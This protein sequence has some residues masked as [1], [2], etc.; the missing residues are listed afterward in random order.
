M[1]GITLV[2]TLCCARAQTDSPFSGDD[3]TAMEELIEQAPPIPAASV[4]HMG[5]FWSAQHA[6]DTRFPW[7]PLP[8]NILG[9]D[10]WSLG[11]GGYLLNDTNLD[12]DALAAAMAT[13]QAAAAPTPMFRMS[14][15]ASSL[16]SAYAY[17]NPVYLTNLVVTN[18]G[19]GDMT[20]SFNIAGGTNF[21]PYDIL[22]TT[23]LLDHVGL[24]NWL[25]IGYTAH[26]YGFSNQ[27]APQS[28]YILAKPQKTMTVA[29]GDDFFGEIDEP[30]GITNAVMVV[31]NFA[32]SMALLNDGTITGWGGNWAPTNLTGV[33]MLAC[34]DYFNVALFTNGTVNAW[35]TGGGQTTTNELNVPANLTNATVI[36]AQG[37]VALALRGNGTVVAWGNSTYGQTNVPA[38]LSNVTAIA[39]GYKHCLAVS[40]G[41]V[42]AWGNNSYGQ[43]SIPAGLSNVW[44]VAASWDHSVALKKDGTVACWGDKNQGLG[45][46]NVPAGLSNVVAIAAG[47]SYYDGT[48]YTLVL[49]SDGSLVS[50]GTS[51]ALNPV[52]GLT[53]VI[54]IGSGGEQALAIRTG[55]PTP[56][57]T[58]EPTDQY[59]VPGGE[60]DFTAM[61][62]GLYGVTYQWQ[63]NG[64]NITGATNATLALTNVQA[65]QEM[66]YYV[67]ITDIGGMGSIVSSNANFYLLTPP[68]VD[69]VAPATNTAVLYNSTENL[70]VTASGPGDSGDF[71]LSYQWEFNGVDISGA[72]SSNYTF[73]AEASGIYTVTISNDIGGLSVSWQ[74]TV[75]NEGGI[76]PWGSNPNGELNSPLLVTN[77]ISLAAGKAQGIAALDS[78]SVTNWGSY[79][80]GTN[81]VSVTAPPLLTNTMAVAAGSRHDLALKTDGTITAWGLN[82]FGQTNVPAGATNTIA[83][84]AGGQQS[85]ALLQNGT[86]VQWG[87]T[88][89]AV[90]AGLAGVTAIA[91]GTNFCLALLSNATVVAWGADNYGQTNVPAGLTNVVAIAAGGAHALALEQNGTVVTWGAWTNV[92]AGLTNAMKIAAGDNQS[93]AI[94]NDG[95]MTAWGDNSYGQTNI[96]GGLTGIKLIAGG[97]DFSLAAA[98][99]PTV[100]YPVNV[101]NDLLLIYNTNSVNSSTVV[102]YYL[103]HRPMV[104]G[105]NV[106]GIGCTNVETFLLA[107]YTNVFAAQVQAWLASNPTKRPQYVVLFP[108]IPSRVNTNDTP[109]WYPWQYFPDSVLLAHQWPSVQYQLATGCATGWNPFVTSINMNGYGGTNDCIGYI[110]KIAAIGTNVFAGSPIVSASANGYGNTN[111]YCDDSQGIYPI[112]PFGLWA[113]QG[114]TSN[115]VPLS[116]VDYQPFTSTNRITLGTNMAGFCSW[117]VY[118]GGGGNYYLTMQ[119]KGNSGWYLIETIESFNGEYYTTGQGSYIKWYSTNAF[120]GT[121]YSS[122]PIGAVT[123]VD[124]PGAVD[125]ENSQIYFGLWAAGKNFAICAWN[126]RQTPFFQAVGDPFVRR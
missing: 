113:L 50:W 22:T 115:G 103:A 21:V 121:N 119:F 49:K 19:A 105:A 99:S 122:T 79:W 84:A 3:I 8:G 86:V 93:L 55:P 28:F 25:G 63:T 118:N 13:A 12:Y 56:V 74:V 124:E 37:S 70:T 85:L 57:L 32:E 67:V 92:P 29:W 110:N 7:P 83:I 38:A 65:A 16:A 94:L 27:P 35:A 97:G 42:V 77:V 6:P 106:L 88:N 98:F 51:D 31:G 100:M 9:L 14:M 91:A 23:N 20:A 120:G 107:E 80:T 89:A 48:A 34:G 15:M 87:Q 39:V 71:P 46:T 62:V 117:G 126:A 26:G 47:G 30:V 73:D 125:C 52:V 24:W 75:F 61:G 76:I 60:A 41:F 72:T 54:A 1:C 109:G 78:G 116:D 17:G 82:D 53:N 104:S 81:Y 90:P 69:A 44:D 36:S 58:L 108:D 4:P 95:T 64:V 10:A 40:N 11:D 43:T 68:V 59:Q 5:T 114:V 112:Y 111:Y 102:N 101:A 96:P 123:H 18:F 66:A 33:G 45:V 2:A